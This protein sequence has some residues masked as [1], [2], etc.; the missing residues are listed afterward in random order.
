MSSA[1][2]SSSNED[3]THYILR[4]DGQVEKATNNT[5]LGMLIYDAS[6]GSQLWSGYCFLRKKPNNE[7]TKNVADY[8]AL[9]DGLRIIQFLSSSSGTTTSLPRVEIQTSND[10]ISKH[11]TGKNRVS[12]KILLPWYRKVC[13]LTKGG[14]VA[15]VKVDKVET[16]LAKQNAMYAVKQRESDKNYKNYQSAMHNILSTTLSNATDDDDLP[17][18]SSKIT[19]SDD[20]MPMVESRTEVESISSNDDDDELNVESDYGDDNDDDDINEEEL[21]FNDVGENQ[22]DSNSSLSS[23]K[24]DD[25]NVI[26]DSTAVA[27]VDNA[28]TPPPPN[29]VEKENE[30]ILNAL[31]S[32]LTMVQEERE[33]LQQEHRNQTAELVE[34]RAK[35]EELGMQQNLALTEAQH[36]QP[37]Q[38]QQSNNQSNTQPI[39]ADIPLESWTEVESISSNQQTHPAQ[40]QQSNQ[41]WEPSNEHRELSNDQPISPDKTYILRFDGGSRGNPGIAGSGMVLYD[42]E[43][44][45]EVWS[46]CQYLGDRFTNNEAEY[47]GLITGLQC[48]RSLGVENIVAQGDSKLILQQVEGKWKVKAKNLTQ[49]YDQARAEIQEFASFQTCHIKRARNARADELANEAMD[50]KQNRGFDI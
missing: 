18:P 22:E 9:S 50:T 46:G 28:T 30:E 35:V 48:A 43:D 41:S 12:S 24:K 45:S 40:Q 49:Y 47:V 5:G 20:T 31:Q 17:S 38:Q 44:G 13:K 29:N 6:N 34:L 23:A 1:S 42:S 7:M 11:L 21:I 3:R 33:T 16:K 27:D 32:K 14:D 4:F 37:A 26:P 25:T 2:S 8:M 36:T 15:T 39:S 10:L 19:P